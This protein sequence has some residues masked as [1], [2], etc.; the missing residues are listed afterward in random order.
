MSDIVT[1]L[2]IL[3]VLAFIASLLRGDDPPQDP[4]GFA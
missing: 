3:A 4:F 2:I 1:I